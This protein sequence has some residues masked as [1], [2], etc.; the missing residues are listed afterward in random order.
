MRTVKGCG[1]TAR[2]GRR[3]PRSA[4]SPLRLCYLP[5]GMGVKRTARLA[6]NNLAILAL[7]STIAGSIGRRV[8]VRLWVIFAKSVPFRSISAPFIAGGPVGQGRLNVLLGME[9]HDYV[10]NW[11]KAGLV[12][13]GAP[14][15]AP[16]PPSLRL[17]RSTS[18]G[19][20]QGWLRPRTRVRGLEVV[21][22]SLVARIIAR[23]CGEIKRVGGNRFGR[24]YAGRLS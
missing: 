14:D 18:S 1:A 7:E 19:E 4:V 9:P 16:S 20:P 6:A 22:L 21:G 17:A 5:R 15:A 23:M 3:K 11:M 2:T 12:G 13:E 24:P 10:R 8:R